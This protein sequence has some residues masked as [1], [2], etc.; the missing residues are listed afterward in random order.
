M[1][2]L[3]LKLVAGGLVL[4]YGHFL[5]PTIPRLILNDFRLVSLDKLYLW[6][7]HRFLRKIARSS[8][9]DIAVLLMVLLQ[10]WFLELGARDRF[11]N[12]ITDNIARRPA[13][14]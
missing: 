9:I 14:P 11:Y 3:G 10:L 5:L 12:M 8:I 6:L 4:G 13:P 1:I 7:Q 2:Q